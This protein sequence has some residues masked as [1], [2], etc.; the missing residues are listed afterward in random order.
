MSNHMKLVAG[1]LLL[2]LTLF[3]AR[4]SSAEP[5]AGVAKVPITTVV[6][7]LGPNYSAP[8]AVGKSDVVVR[9]GKVR[10]DIVGWDAAQGDKSA[11]ELAILIDD[12]TNIGNQL[13]DLRKFIR[14]QS[15]ATSVGLFYASSGLT[16]AVSPF[17]TDHDAVAQKLRITL[18]QFRISTSIYLAIMD[19]MS[20]WRPSGARRE[21]LVIADGIDRFRGDPYSPDVILTIQ[22]AQKAGIMI[23]TLFAR[24]SDRAG[25]NSFRAGY[26]QSNLAQ[27]TDETG[28]ESFFQGFDT[29]ISFTPFLDQLDMVL[30]NQYFLTFTTL[31]STKKNGEYR[32][33][34][35]STEQQNVEISGARHV[36]VPGR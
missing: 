33:F 30:H 10:E 5:Q 18:G 36:W 13:D 3:T 32:G 21:I 20:K 16:Q 28:G 9:T 27:M 23:H 17:S 14:A 34:R 15:K 11:L 26:G 7:V 35:V 6:S 12:G 25:R 24:D 4:T 2:S 29:P 8:P 22:R 31:S 1:L 19:L